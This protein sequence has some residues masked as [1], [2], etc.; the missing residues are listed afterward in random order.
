MSKVINVQNQAIKYQVLKFL[1]SFLFQKIWDTAGQE[2]YKSLT[3]LYYRG[4]IYVSTIKDAQIA[5]IVYDISNK[6]S[7][8]V[9]KSWI[10]DL[11][12][13]GPKKLI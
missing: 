10:K 3:P 6:Q 1:I 12:D 5:L 2:K 8:E 7:F 13:H 9:L 11:K 4:I